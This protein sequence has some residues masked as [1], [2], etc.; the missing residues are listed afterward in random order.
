MSGVPGIPATALAV[1]VSSG[2]DAAVLA[3]LA[4]PDARALRRRA[5]AATTRT[6]SFRAALLAAGWR[7]RDVKLWLRTGS[8]PS[9]KRPA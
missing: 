6:S 4:A 9:S 3:R 5:L 2:I 8:A 1:A 7:K